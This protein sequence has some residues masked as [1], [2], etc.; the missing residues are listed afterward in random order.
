[1]A[2]LYQMDDEKR[3]A[4]YDSLKQ[5]YGLVDPAQSA[6]EEAAKSALEQEKSDLGWQEAA[7]RFA[8]AGQ[9]KAQDIANQ[10]ANKKKMAEQDIMGGLREKQQ[11]RRQAMSDNM[12]ID[13]LIQGRENSE[14]DRADR[15][16]RE[17]QARIDKIE[18]RNYKTQEK[19][20]D[21]GLKQQEKLK[22]SED[23]NK[24]SVQEVEDR[25]I[26]IDQNLALLD[27][28]VE[29][30][31][32]QEWFGPQESEMR[33]LINEI[34]TD[35]AKLAD[36]T[37]V[38]RPSE[39]DQAKEGLFEPGSLTTRN[40]TARSLI[41]KY[42]DSINRRAET[43]YKVRGLT[44]PQ[45]QKQ[46]AD[47]AAPKAPLAPPPPSDDVAVSWALANAS[48]SDPVTKNQAIEILR[49]NKKLD[50]KVGVR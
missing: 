21:L 8:Y 34:A 42:R 17:K 6:E 28:L 26:N 20:L 19:A 45:E 47:M 2:D 37:S 12:A 16:S 29:D 49:V 5:K 14:E 32:T 50:S 1:M 43:A 44:P 15:I 4:L 23:K 9:D 18:D 22:E 30:K 7:Q 10:Y 27:K 35:T 39:V 3:K 24:K 41:Q 48:S 36:P 31:G 40:A 13:N 25:R 46:V 11:A 33:R 38:A